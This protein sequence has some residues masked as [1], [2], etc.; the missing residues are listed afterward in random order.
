M[1]RSMNCKVFWHA[2]ARLIDLET[3]DS[4]RDS[5]SI[6][7][8]GRVVVVIRLCQ[9]G[10]SVSKCVAL[11][12]PGSKMTEVQYIGFVFEDLFP[13]VGERVCD[14]VPQEHRAANLQYHLNHLTT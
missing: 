3:V 4:F 12:I 1:L 5:S 9:R 10:S 11:A 13:L 2:Q 6:F 14:R 8:P 7:K